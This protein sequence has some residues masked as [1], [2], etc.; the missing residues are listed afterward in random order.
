MLAK[1]LECSG[2]SVQWELG[3]GWRLNRSDQ[4]SSSRETGAPTAD[5]GR[6]QRT[7]AR[8][9]RG[10]HPNPFTSPSP[11]AGWRSDVAVRLT[12]R[13]AETRISGSLMRFVD[14]AASR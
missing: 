1:Q 13:S 11:D 2:A 3:T 8:F 12:V 10:A 4:A 9:R 5:V 14:G 6:H 7:G